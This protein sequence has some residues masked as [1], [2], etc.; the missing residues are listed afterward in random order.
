VC[1]AWLADAHG[2]TDLSESESTTLIRA[3]GRLSTVRI[4]LIGL[5]GNDDAA[6]LDKADGYVSKTFELRDITEKVQDVLS[7]VSLLASE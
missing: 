6:C 3:D 1:S 4:I 5:P 2:K 7:A